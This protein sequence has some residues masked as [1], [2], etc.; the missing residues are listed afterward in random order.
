LVNSHELAH[1]TY[2][3]QHKK[4]ALRQSVYKIHAITVSFSNHLK[5]VFVFRLYAQYKRFRA[6]CQVC[7]MGCN[8]GSNESCLSYV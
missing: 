7:P 8:T 6:A 2:L 1:P 3:T 4:Q 5:F